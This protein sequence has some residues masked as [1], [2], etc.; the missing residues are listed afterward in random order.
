MEY[1]ML[2][3]IVFVLLIFI[4]LLVVIIV[5]SVKRYKKKPT[6][7]DFMRNPFGNVYGAAFGALE[8]ASRLDRAFQ[9]VISNPCEATAVALLNELN[10]V[11]ELFKFGMSNGRGVN[12]ALWKNT[13][14]SYIVN[15][16]GIK[17]ETKLAIREALIRLSVDHLSRVVD[18][19]AIGDA[20]EA[21]VWFSLS[22]LA[23]NAPLNAF[24]SVRLPYNN[25]GSQEIDNII[26]CSKGVLLVEIKTKLPGDGR[27]VTSAE[28]PN[29]YE[30]ISEHENAFVKNFGNIPHRN[31]LVLSYP[32][33]QFVQYDMST[34]PP[35]DKYTTLT[36]DTLY[37]YI[38]TLQGP[39]VLDATTIEA[40]STQLTSSKY[41]NYVDN[42][43]VT[44]WVVNGREESS[45]KETKPLNFC[46][47]CGKK[48]NAP[49]SFCAFC[50]Q[51]L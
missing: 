7:Q 33:N 15:N 47:Q 46:P 44:K 31:L 41:W 8:Q 4:I 17:T 42:K 43:R 40:L 48:L 24:F 29:P 37:E 26:V 14:N 39:D 36:V 10:S 20:G 32:K 38:S 9:T 16:N 45:L 11:D 3:P 6:M 1:L 35:N 34:F 22:R 18:T 25:P 51:K 21:N 5:S 12:T 30:Q 19:K 49:A 50:G 2:L 28:I 27:V 23:A 13:F